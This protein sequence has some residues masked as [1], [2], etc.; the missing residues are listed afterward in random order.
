MQFTN[1]SKNIA[2]LKNKCS[3]TKPPLKKYCWDSK[4]QYLFNIEWVRTTK[5]SI[6]FS[7]SP[8]NVQSYLFAFWL[9]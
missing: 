6:I 2:D 3:Y 9:S 1:M 7:D 8:G 5:F 4:K